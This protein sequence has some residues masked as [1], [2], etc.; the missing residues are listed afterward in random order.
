MTTLNQQQDWLDLDKEMESLLGP[1]SDTPEERAEAEDRRREFLANQR[2][3]RRKARAQ[4]RKEDPENL[5]A[6]LDDLLGPDSTTSE[7]PAETGARNALQD[8]CE[9]LDAAVGPN[10]HYPTPAERAEAKETQERR[11]AALARV[12]FQHRLQAASE[13][14]ARSFALGIK[15]AKHEG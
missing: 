7:E 11:R 15:E 10:D 8:L 13:A 12:A 2:Y 6:I 5:D 9:A 14:V 3:E 1:D 4:G